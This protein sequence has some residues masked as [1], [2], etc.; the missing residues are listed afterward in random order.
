ML[1]ERDRDLLADEGYVVLPFL[2]ASTVDELREGFA[3]IHPEDRTDT[4]VTDYMEW[5]RSVMRS[6][7]ALVER[8]VL[9]HLADLVPGFQLVMATFVAKYPGPQSTMYLHDDRSFVDERRARALT[10]WIPLDDVGPDTGNGTLELVPRSHRIER[11]PSG[12]NSPDLYR[13]WERFLRTHLQ[14]VAA[15]AGSAVLYD[16]RVL[17]ASGPN[18]GDR[19][20]VA[21]AMALAPEDE[22]LIHVVDGPDA[23]RLHAVGP[24]FFLDHH[25]R[26]IEAQMPASC[27]VIEVLDGRPRLDTTSLAEL[28]GEVPPTDPVVPH[29]LRL[30][31]EPWWFDWLAHVDGPPIA[32]PPG[33]EG[34]SSKT[35]V[36]ERTEGR[37]VSSAGGLLGKKTTLALDPGARIVVRPRR[38]RMHLL[39]HTVDAPSVGAGIRAQAARASDLRAGRTVLLPPGAPATVW[40]DGPTVAIVCVVASR[41]SALAGGQTGWRRWGGVGTQGSSPSA[42]PSA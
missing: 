33:R 9:P 6:T 39:V 27:P 38:P 25:P 29:D 18:C 20:R 23:A 13:P 28:F 4:I 30:D 7:R 2:S 26:Q 31:G 11:G 32:S 19:P 10:A 3:L 15:R 37:V 5:D 21:L 24:D 16:C 42:M 40:N 8:L 12:S 35:L 17:H 41:A 22:Q 36:I 34:R 1:R 14:P